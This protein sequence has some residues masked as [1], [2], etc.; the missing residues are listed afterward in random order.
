MKVFSILFIIFAIICSVSCLKCYICDPEID[1]ENCK[2][3]TIEDHL[4]K[5]DDSNETKYLEDQNNSGTPV[6]E[7]YKIVMEDNK[8]KRGP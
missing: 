3:V 4:R 5:C 6:Y 7:C 2:S 1:D 8:V